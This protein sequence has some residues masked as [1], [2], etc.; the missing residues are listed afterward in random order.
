MKCQH[1]GVNCK[2]LY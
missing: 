2:K 1:K